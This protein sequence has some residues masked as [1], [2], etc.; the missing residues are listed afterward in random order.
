[1]WQSNQCWRDWFRVKEQW[2]TLVLIKQ[3][4]KGRETSR[5]ALD[6]LF[7]SE[8]FRW[9]FTHGIGQSCGWRCTWAQLHDSS[10][11][12]KSLEGMLLG[13]LGMCPP[14][15]VG[16]VSISWVNVELGSA[17][18]ARNSTAAQ[19]KEKGWSTPCCAH[20]SAGPSEP[21]LCQQQ[22]LWGISCAL[23]KC[24]RAL[25]RD[26]HPNS[27][28]HSLSDTTCIP[29]GSSRGAAPWR[30]CVWHWIWYLK[31][32]PP[33]CSLWQKRCHFR[34]RLCCWW[35][36][37]CTALA[38]SAHV[39]S[40][41]GAGTWSCSCGRSPTRRG[42]VHA[43]SVPTLLQ[44]WEYRQPLTQQKALCENLSKILR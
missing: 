12:G 43:A 44:Q 14:L 28:T 35:P 22:I 40:V 23:G 1:M 39:W 10:K 26:N 24:L 42:E 13:L 31:H 17:L 18:S 9:S 41:A 5:A 33:L 6:G 19:L 16:N 2:R 3:G 21:V 36:P 8:T 25:G 27:S 37:T 11:G 4:C 29:G 30:S 38:F 15:W 34:Q 7:P 32:D 20:S